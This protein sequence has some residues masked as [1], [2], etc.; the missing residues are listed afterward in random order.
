MLSLAGDGVW[1]KRETHEFSLAHLVHSQLADECSVSCARIQIS[2]GTFCGALR[3][4]LSE[5]ID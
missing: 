3:V 1:G 2:N 5:F 4:T